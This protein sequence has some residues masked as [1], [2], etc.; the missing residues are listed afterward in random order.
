MRCDSVP[1]YI[2]LQN[3]IFELPNC[4]IPSS[5]TLNDPSLGMTGEL[6]VSNPAPRQRRRAPS[7]PTPRRQIQPRRPAP[8][9]PSSSA[10]RPERRAAATRSPPYAPPPPRQPIIPS[11][12]S[13]F[14]TFPQKSWR[15]SPGLF[16]W[17]PPGLRRLLAPDPH[18]LT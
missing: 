3:H 16:L 4:P 11:E 15:P 2:P 5:P 9:P 10:I 1:R 7:P 18:R 6:W 14:N 17:Q 12:G 13:D 8:S